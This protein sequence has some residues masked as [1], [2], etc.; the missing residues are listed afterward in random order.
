M[1]GS[2][3]YDPPHVKAPHYEN[4]DDHMTFGVSDDLTGTRSRN[5]RHTPLFM[6]WTHIVGQL[7]P[8]NAIGHLAEADPTPTLLT[9]YDATAC[10]QGIERPHLKDNG[11]SVVVYI[12]K[13]AVS[14]EFASSMVCLARAVRPAIPFVLAVQ[15]VLTD[16]LHTPPK[17][18]DGIITRI[19]AVACDPSDADLPVDYGTRY[20]RQCW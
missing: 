6:F 17:G 8:I 10:F 20:R 4:R 14:I 16:A 7:P 12:L 1:A 5:F 3:W 11:D 2:A 13:P 15:A 18:I 19:E 9:L